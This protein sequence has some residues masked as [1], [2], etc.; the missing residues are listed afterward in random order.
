MEIVH[1]VKAV[2]LN[3]FS[4]CL[5]ITILFPSNDKL[6]NKSTLHFP[7]LLYKSLKALYSHKL[8]N[9]TAGGEG[10]HHLGDGEIK[11][12]VGNDVAHS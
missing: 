5:L 2:K 12:G 8:S 1:N 10:S 4:V 7:L 11:Y 6:R 3:T 9:V